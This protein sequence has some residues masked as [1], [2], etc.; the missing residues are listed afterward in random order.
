[1]SNGGQG[2][3]CVGPGTELGPAQGVD[4]ADEQLARQLLESARTIAVV[5]ASRNPAK[6]AHQIPAELAAAGYHVIPVNPTPPP[7][8]T[9]VDE[10]FGVA[11]VPHLSDIAEPIDLVDVFRPA[12]ECP[13]VARDA[14]AVGAKALWLQLGIV[15]C[16][17]RAIAE[18]GGLAYVENRCTGADR[19]RWG[20][21][22][23][24]RLR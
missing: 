3:S 19:R 20:I 11:V 8:G 7:A 10:L 22:A 24:S 1:M 4:V 6:A 9:E 13:D 15:S 17:A 5:G 21:S 14:V 23:P 18:A 2:V 12:H 16:G